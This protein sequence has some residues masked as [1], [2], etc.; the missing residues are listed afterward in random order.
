ML[1][2]P[3]GGQPS[4]SGVWSSPLP[5]P[6]ASS[7]RPVAPEEVPGVS[8]RRGRKFGGSLAQAGS[9]STSPTS[10]SPLPRGIPRR[11]P[12][13]RDLGG[14]R[15][16]SPQKVPGVSRRRRRKFGGSLAQ[17]GSASRSPRRA[18]FFPGESLAVGLLSV[19]LEAPAALRRPLSRS[20]GRSSTL[21]FP[22]ASSGGPVA[23]EAEGQNRRRAAYGCRLG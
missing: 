1:P 14:S 2:P 12:L 5:F 9:A 10:R 13:E 17:A 15:A 20:G 11:R 18:A 8:R 3:S 16:P 4:R 7:G 21:P 22:I 19:L 23:G 6:I